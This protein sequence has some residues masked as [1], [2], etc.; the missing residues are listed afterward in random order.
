M[1]ERIPLLYIDDEVHN[2]NAFKASFRRDYEIHTTSQVTEAR[3]ILEECTIPIIIADQRM[4]GTSGVEF[5]NSIKTSS[6]D[7]IRILITAYTDI[8]SIIDSI[9][10]GEIY[11]YVK[12]PWEY[13]D[14]RNTI[15]NAYEIYQTRKELN[16][17][18]RG[19]RK[20]KEERKRFIDHISQEVRGILLSSLGIVN[21]MKTDQSLNGNKESFDILGENLYRL[22]DFTQQM[23]AYYTN[24]DALL[25]YNEIDFTDLLQNF[26][27]SF[28]S[29]LVHFQVNVQQDQVCYG[30]VF[31]IKTIL[32]NLIENAI[33][34]KNLDRG[35]VLIDIAVKVENEGTE[36]C[37]SDN[38]VGIE[39][40]DI[41]KI[42]ELFFHGDNKQAGAGIG[43]FVV[44]EAVVRMNGEIAISSK[45]EEGTTITVKLPQ[46]W[47]SR[48]IEKSL[49][50]DVH[51][52]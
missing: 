47:E 28:S 20:N 52:L 19:L 25:K 38:G 10:K 1:K 2:L 13:Y 22:K 7:A 9:N 21:L 12:K 44:H 24:A 8:E 17:Q 6:S 29:D 5:F 30:D 34:F 3:K 15:T 27:K 31:R 50:A 11:R 45:V 18:I 33:R 39:E 40:A 42:F 32:K 14:L 35:N 37:I 43:L 16:Q 48:E 46:H 4:P 49:N 23:I 51:S 36:I 41:K 26:V